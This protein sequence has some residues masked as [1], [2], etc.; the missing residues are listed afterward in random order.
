MLWWYLS[1]WPGVLQASYPTF[2]L[3]T[4]TEELVVSWWLLKKRW[5]LRNKLDI[6]R[7]DACIHVSIILETK[8]TLW[9]SWIVLASIDHDLIGNS[10]ETKQNTNKHNQTKTSTLI[11]RIYTP[12]NKHGTWKWT[13]GKGYSY[14]KPPFPGSMLIF[15]RVY[16]INYCILPFLLRLPYLPCDRKWLKRKRCKVSPASSMII[17]VPSQFIGVGVSCWICLNAS[18]VIHPKWSWIIRIIW[19]SNGMQWKLPLFQ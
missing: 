3:S 7:R 11:N 14:W 17:H 15:G 2:F 5:W 19:H 13:L 1:I 16:T 9:G 12:Q 4:Y 6:W 10:S 18:S 8:L